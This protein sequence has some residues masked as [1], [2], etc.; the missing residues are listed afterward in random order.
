MRLLR[1]GQERYPSDAGPQK[2]INQ[3]CMNL[4]HL[5]LLDFLEW[6]IKSIKPRFKNRELPLLPAATRPIGDFILSIELRCSN[7]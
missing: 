7:E 5:S 3:I 6:M 2:K 1:K 4:R